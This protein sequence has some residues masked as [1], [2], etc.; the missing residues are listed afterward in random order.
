V[1]AVPVFVL[2]VSFNTRDL[3]AECLDSIGRTPETHQVTVVD[4]GSSDGSAGMV[5]ER[6]PE[7]HLIAR[8]DNIGF[9]GGVND[10]LGC[11]ARGQDVLLLNSDAT[12]SAGCL[13]Q[14]AATL[15][16]EPEVGIVA[17]LVVHP[18]GRLRIISAGNQPTVWRLFT[19]YS[20]LSRWSRHRR[21]LEGM[22]L[23]RGL[24]DDRLR[25]VQWVSGA[26][27][28]VRGAV[29]DQVGPLSTRWFMYAEDLEF[30]SRATAA[31]W[32]IVH[33]PGAR[34]VHHVG[35][36]SDHGGPVSTMWIRSTEDYYRERF[37]PSRVQWWLW[38]AILAAGLASRAAVYLIRARTD[39]QHTRLWR[40]NATQFLVYAKAAAS[41]VSR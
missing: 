25:E 7:V 41:G 32:R 37:G 17:P 15:D 40:T 31:G 12:L 27:M 14:L 22:H 30:C 35:A 16:A 24:H 4:N 18:D 26:C 2:V 39:P 38:H 33:D 21:V 6:F 19:H 9:A 3:L 5:R 28:L 36:S 20:G 13:G 23:L 8:P 11:R 29:F 10:G 34:V 1:S